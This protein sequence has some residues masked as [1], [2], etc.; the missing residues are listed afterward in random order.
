MKVKGSSGV[1]RFK[2][3]RDFG[4]PGLPEEMILG[5]DDKGFV[6]GMEFVLPHRCG[7]ILRRW[8]PDR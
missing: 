4:L 7:R 2:S 8:L 3:S 6:A 1:G 5:A